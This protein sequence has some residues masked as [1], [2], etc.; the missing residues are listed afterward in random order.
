VTRRAN[1]DLLRYSAAGDGAGLYL[2]E[3]GALVK[4]G[5]ARNLRFRL[6]ELHCA[7]RRLGEQ[8]GEFRVFHQ[9][10]LRHRELCMAEVAC[11]RALADVA[12][13][14][15]GRREYFEGLSLQVAESIVR[16]GLPPAPA[17]SPTET[18]KA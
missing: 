7:H 3:V 2:A 1:P 6:K 12:A 8:I 18:Q 14:A 4:I 5:R 15:A 16:A 11:I 17:T 10:N 9:P 13:P